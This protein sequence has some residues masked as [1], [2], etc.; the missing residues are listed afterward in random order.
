MKKRVFIIAEAGVNHNG[1]LRKALKMVD[2]AKTAGADAVKFQMFRAEDLVTKNA[3]K[4]KYQKGTTRGGSQYDML[5]RLELEE[6]DFK[7]L[8]NY[9]RKKKIEFMATP[10]DTESAGFLNKLGMKRFKISSGDLTNIPLL[11]VIAKFGKP[12]ILSTGMADIKGVSE[13]V[14]AIKRKGNK[15]ITLL[16]CTSNYPTKMKDVNLKAMLELKRTFG[17][18][19]GYSDHTMGIE[20]SV[21]AAGMGAEVVEKHFT[22]DRKMKGPDHRASLEPKELKEL[23]NDV[24]NVTLAL[25]DGRKVPSMSEMDT[26]KVA[27][28]SIVAAVD[29]IKGSKLESSMLDVKRPGTGIEPK[30]LKKL[31]G[32]FAKSDIKNETVIKW[33]MLS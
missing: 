21:A 3:P 7:R 19:A 13:A 5:K 31:L 24:R 26:K 14:A 11:E 28:K 29:I 1:D 18:P 12:V 30:Y 22:L 27:R 23:V 8:F 15:K 9:C 32:M 25:G 33:G 4:A 17:F 20:V 6:A 2:A 16:H 10:F